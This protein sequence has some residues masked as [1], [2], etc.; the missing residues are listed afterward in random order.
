MGIPPTGR[1]ETMRGIDI[2]RVREGR[3]AEQW[4]EVDTL[5]ILQQIGAIPRRF[6]ICDL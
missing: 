5:G 2:F 1:S 4:G 3:I 6:N